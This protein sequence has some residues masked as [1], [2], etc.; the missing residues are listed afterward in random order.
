M[1]HPLPAI[2]GGPRIRPEGPPDWPAPDEDVRRALDEVYRDGSWGKY[3]GNFMPKLEERLRD[4]FGVEFVQTC[5][6]GTF[7]VELALRA[8]KIGV[9]DEVIVA[10]YD[11]PG[12]FLSIHAVGA[13]PVLVDIDPNNWNLDPK[14]LQAARGPMVRAILVSHLHGG[15]VPMQELTAWATA[16]GLYV[17]EDAA[18]APGA[19]V[20]GRK[21]GTWGDVGTLSFGGSKLLTAGRGGAILTRHADANQRARL[22]LQRGNSICPLSEL[23]ASV[24]LPQLDKL[25]EQN[26]RRVRSAGLLAERLQPVP[27]IRPF[28]NANADDRACYYKFGLQFDSEQFGLPRDRLVVS[29]RAEGIALDEGFLALHRGRSPTRFRAGGELNEA[30]KAHDGALVLHHP[31]LLGTEAEVQQVAEALDKIHA[32]ADKL[33]ERGEE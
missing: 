21:A 2:L 16:H 1:S 29:V 33:R 11:Y 15:L 7:A 5:A 23:Q 12:N 8:L 20:Q 19:I 13:R 26:A 17:V 27:G 3:F 14:R 18:Q 28:T 10:A 25:D 6:S 30:S 32:H 22:W 4:Y 9:G 24:L 31:V